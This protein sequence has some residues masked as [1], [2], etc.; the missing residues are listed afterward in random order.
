MHVSFI[1][2]VPLEHV[3]HCRD[4]LLETAERPNIAV[5]FFIFSFVRSI[6]G[7][8][9]GNEDRNLNSS[10]FVLYGVGNRTFNETVFLIHEFGPALPAL[11]VQRFNPTLDTNDDVVVETVSQGSI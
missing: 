2:K 11:S 6:N 1:F 5:L 3:L 10:L 8:V 7:T 9:V 4:C